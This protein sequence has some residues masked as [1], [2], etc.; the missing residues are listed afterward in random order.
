MPGS[1]ASATIHQMTGRLLIVDDHEGFRA[2]A[3]ALFTEAGYDVVGGADSAASAEEAARRLR[4]DVVLLDIQLPDRPGFTV[5]ATLQD[6][7]A[8]VVL[9]SGRRAADFGGQIEASG[10]DGFV[11]KDEL[12]GPRLL[13]LIGPIGP[14]P[15]DH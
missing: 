2:T 6:L 4:P 1:V 14:G 13:E 8:A 10:A 12:S 5:V 7:G 3:A 11:A 9:T 15:V